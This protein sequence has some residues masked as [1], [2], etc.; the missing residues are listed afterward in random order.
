MRRRFYRV[1][2]WDVALLAAVAGIGGVLSRANPT[3]PVV[4]VP[5]PS[6]AFLLTGYPLP[7]RPDAI[8]WIAQ[9]RL[10]IL[11]A[12]VVARAVRCVRAVGGATAPTR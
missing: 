12:L 5:D 2:A 1:L 7:P 3:I 6:P 8:E 10:E 11:S 4:V 9:W